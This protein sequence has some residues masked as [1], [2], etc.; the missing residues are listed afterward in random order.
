MGKLLIFNF[1]GTSNEPED[2]EQEFDNK[3]AVEDENITNVLKFHLLCGGNLKDEKPKKSA[4]Q[5]SFYYNGVGTYGNF[6]QRLY[7]AGLSSEKFDVAKILRTALANFGDYYKPGDKVLVT[8]FSRGAALARRFASLINDKVNGKDV[9]EA[10][11]DTVAAIGMPNMNPAD[12]PK[13]E[14]VFENGHTLPSNVKLALHCLSIDDKRKAFQPTLMNKEDKITEVWF[15]GAH[16][17]V[18]GGYY[19]DGLAD[20]AFR[21]MLDWIDDL[22]WNVS[23]ISPASVDYDKLV[24]QGAGYSISQDDVSI[25]PNVFGKSHEQTRNALVAWATLTDRIICVVQNDEFTNIQ[26]VVHHSVA[27]RIAGDK[28]YLPQS[29]K[30]VAHKIRYDDG[31]EVYFKGYVVHKENVLNRLNMLAV[32]EQTK[33]V[34]LSYLLYNRTGIFIEKGTEYAISVN[35]VAGKDQQ[36]RDADVTCDA[37]GWDRGDVTMGLKE[38]AI[39]GMEPFRRVPEADWFC[40]CG[41]IGDKDDNSFKI[42]KKSKVKAPASGELCLFANDLNRFYGNNFGK[43]TVTIKRVA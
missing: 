5:I 2:A 37:D 1:D 32:G 19:Y 24:E 22:D 35:K 42:G 11:F 9:I 4:K 41:S 12:R 7:N 13:S 29:L 36:W 27:Q 28:N 34:A 25:D 10:V 33:T 14:V 6:F 30:K 17:D 31:S 43:L 40:L 20:L 39:A 38:I 18:G 8:G 21:F 23:V 26:P 3:G 16:S 15:A